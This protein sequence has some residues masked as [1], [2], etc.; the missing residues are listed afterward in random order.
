MGHITFLY[1][2]RGSLPLVL[3]SL[4]SSEEVFRRPQLS[5]PCQRNGDCCV[6]LQSELGQSQHVQICVSSI[7]CLILIILIILTSPECAASG[8]QGAQ[9]RCLHPSGSGGGPL[10]SWRG[11]H[12][13]ASSTLT[14][15][16]THMEAWQQHAVHSPQS[17]ALLSQPV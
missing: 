10:G 1:S 13:E 7:T 5:Q 15:G 16:K 11:S 9:A 3:V 12:H 17:A 6:W 2:N 4:D 14:L 8:D